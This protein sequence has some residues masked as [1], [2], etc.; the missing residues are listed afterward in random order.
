VIIII[1]NNKIPLKTSH[2]VIYIDPCPPSMVHHQINKHNEK[3]IILINVNYC[4]AS[5]EPSSCAGTET[6]KYLRLRGYKQHVVF[7][8]FLSLAQLLR[9]NIKN[10]ILLSA[11][12]SF[13][14]LPFSSDFFETGIYSPLSDLKFLRSYFAFENPLPNNRH[15]SAN[16]WGLFQL[17]RIH[18]IVIGCISNESIEVENE[19]VLRNP[20]VNSYS[21]LVAIFLY[22]NSTLDLNEAPAIIENILSGNGEFPLSYR[23][24]GALIS[25]HKPKILYIDDH[26]DRGWSLVIQNILYGMTSNDFRSIDTSTLNSCDEVMNT[27]LITINKDHWKPDIILLDL[28]LFDEKGVNKDITKLS[29]YR[30]LVKIRESVEFCS[31][32]IIIMTASNKVGSFNSLIGMGA[33][34]YWIKEGIDQKLSFSESAENYMKFKEMIYRVTE[35]SEYQLLK[36]L[37]YLLR[38][39]EQS[40]ELWWTKTDRFRETRLK[41]NKHEVIEIIK[42]TIEVYRGFLSSKYLSGS[43]TR[44]S[45]SWHAMLIARLNLILELIHESTKR[46]KAS[47][48]P[49]NKRSNYETHD[50]EPGK[51][52]PLF[53]RDFLRVDLEQR[54]WIFARLLNL[55][56]IGAHKF[57]I[58]F[59]QLCEYTILL[60][61][62]LCNNP[63]IMEK[64]RPGLKYFGIV[65]NQVSNDDNSDSSNYTMI[66]IRNLHHKNKVLSI[67][68]NERNHYPNIYINQVVKF[69]LGHDNNEDVFYINSMETL[70]Y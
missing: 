3:C 32:P 69:D 63:L 49:K 66:P 41:V 27:I 16:W 62:Y 7:Y 39:L 52:K 14:R 43:P 29:G 10:S 4:F 19:L 45:D 42:D 46:M 26:A 67:Q 20:D 22:E 21:G 56:N 51:R 53:L 44:F 61:E 58:S 48:Q 70:E 17:W 5:V 34:C 28:R 55:R 31:I 9:L 18:R 60:A 59:S 2:E 54:S 12:T 13:F 64:P 24:M 57:T 1:D 37:F 36:D 50:T 40:D 38:H 6:L 23:S 65:T 8:S 47:Y 11:G 30:I 15:Y 68:I 25:K 33:D 35:S